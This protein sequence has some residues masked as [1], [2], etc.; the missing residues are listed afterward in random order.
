MRDLK[1]SY[2]NLR[3][4]GDL[5]AANFLQIDESVGASKICLELF[6]RDFRRKTREGGYKNDMIDHDWLLSKE[7][8]CEDNFM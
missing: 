2:L 1:S 6:S 5:G 8:D 7:E 4:N 3:K